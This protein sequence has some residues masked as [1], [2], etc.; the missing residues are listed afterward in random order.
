MVSGSAMLLNRYRVFHLRFDR[1]Q[2]F[3]FV[4]SIFAGLVNRSR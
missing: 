4:G 3:S 2:L 1:D